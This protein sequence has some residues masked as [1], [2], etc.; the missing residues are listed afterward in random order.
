MSIP[1][2][3]KLGYYEIRSLLG[4]GGMG[5]VYLADDLRLHRP[6]ALKLLRADLAADEDRLL[7]F[8]REAYA[9]SS[10]N[11]P[12]ILTIYEIGREGESHFIATEFIDGESLGRHLLRGPVQLQE[13]LEI[14]IQ[15]AS[16]LAAAHAAGI[17]HR[18]IKPDNIMLRSDRLVKVVD[19]GIAKLS[20]QQDAAS[21]TASLYVTAPGT[22]IGTAP[23]MS[24][25]QV[26][27]ELVDGRTDI[28]SL[29]V[30]LYQMVG[31]HLPF[32]GKTMTE[33]I[34]EIL[35]TD[36]PVLTR[37]VSHVP[38]ELER[39]VTKALRKD[40]E[41]R[42][43]VVKD[44]GLDL[45][46]LKQR[47]EFEAELKRSGE[48]VVRSGEASREVA[49]ADLTDANATQ[50]LGTP[51]DRA[52]SNARTTSSAEY[53]VSEIKRHKR[54]LTLALL[55][56]IVAIAGAGWWLYSFLLRLQPQSRST[57]AVF[58]ITPFTSF[59]GNES[60]P[61]FSP[62]GNRIAFSWNG[63][64]GDN[65]DIYVKQIGT[66]DLQ[67]LTTDPAA[68][69]EPRWSPDGL[70]I[71]F[72]RQTAEDYGLYLIPS[73]GGQERHLTKLSLVPPS[74]FDVVQVGW[75]PNGE[76]LAISDKGSPKEPYCLFAV[77]RDAG[78]RRRL[79]SPPAGVTGDLSPAVSP[80]GKTVAYKHFESGGVSEIY[81][82]P[83]AG[84]EPKRL[85]F[86]DV[87]KLSPA[88]TPDGRDILFLAESGSSIGLWRVPAAGGT[89]ER[90][91]AA[92]QAVTSFTISPQGNRLAWTQT[93]NDTNIWQVELSGTSPRKQSAKMLISSTK[94]DVSSQ[95]SPD[96]K[97][98]VFA[99]TR[100][101]RSGIWVSDSDG[102][103]QVQVA[104][105]DR[106]AAGSP[107]WSPDGR[108]IVFD[109]RV[110]GNAD[111]Y[112]ISP[113]GGKP[114]RLTSEPSEDVVPSFS[115]D[116]QWIYFCSNR[117]GVLQIWK[118][119][120]AGGQA[121][122]VTRGGGFDNVESPDG[123]F[124][125]YVKER[126]EPGIWRVPVAGGEETPVLD[127]HR[128]GLW[129]QWAVVEQGIFFITAETPDR[130]L[131]EFFSFATGKASLVMTLE[132]KLPDTISGLSVSPDG[133]RLIWTQLDQISSD[134]M[135]IKNFR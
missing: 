100:S 78:E 97:R 105:F 106:G 108:W 127:H 52:A 107:R 44:L 17:V 85:T 89:P 92:G 133:R 23:Y 49:E 91:E 101:G 61:S 75:A 96:G 116:G 2:G 115:R 5:E 121:L 113:E 112:L 62:D 20:E 81:L 3:A 4:A 76:W 79:T 63:E 117:S 47:L 128:A 114:R 48:R 99:S 21:E 77:T 57:G 94:V 16:A 86:S 110:E 7:R 41:E 39:I 120:A 26:R 18:D 8:K 135:L 129:R 109:G 87:V 31:G 25:E 64:Q 42:Y 102:Q 111:I 54:S 9:A 123:Q 84:G 33:V 65:T 15:V 67:R 125:Y 6:V 88:W 19:F 131:I 132:K 14:S 40:R 126:G 34:A 93:I 10:L 51:T 68:D 95:F 13:V 36:P 134:I 82:A 45:K 38:A 71:A 122:Q 58:E 124:L 22:V 55:V 32:T 27:G 118:L 30:V 73:I 90:V 98:I 53:V 1:S 130:P 11:H 50:I 35:K 83:V 56:F 66:E 46:I 80:D 12:N 103:R 74:R 28:W 43:Q 119:P 104:S 59:P 72:L 70:Y 24:P 60:L 37:Y 69:I 29:G